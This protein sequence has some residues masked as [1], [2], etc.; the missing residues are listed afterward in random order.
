LHKCTR[1]KWVLSRWAER[2]SGHKVNGILRCPLIGGPLSAVRTSAAVPFFA[3]MPRR[4]IPPASSKARREIP[5]QAR[6]GWPSTRNMV[7]PPF[8]FDSST[9]S[10]S[11][12]QGKENFARRVRSVVERRIPVGREEARTS[13]TWWPWYMSKLSR[14]PAPRRCGRGCSNTM[15]SYGISAIRE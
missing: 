3:A 8:I 2:S 9:I 5:S 6:V 7:C 11:T 10:G 13:P 14:R 4:E 1:R 12:M 15:S